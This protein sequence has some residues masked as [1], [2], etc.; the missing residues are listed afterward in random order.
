MT[1]IE[2]TQSTPDLTGLPQEVQASF[3]AG[4]IDSDQVETIRRIIRTDGHEA[5]LSTLKYFE[6]LHTFRPYIEIRGLRF[7]I[8][9]FTYHYQLPD[10]EKQ[11]IA[12][13]LEEALFIIATDRRVEGYK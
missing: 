13:A 12:A 4:R 6:K 11:K 2:F 8:H 3:Q 10:S 1:M 7:T 5:G 9:E